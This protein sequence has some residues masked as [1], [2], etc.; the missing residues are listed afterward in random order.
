MTYGKS[1]STD[2]LVILLENLSKIFSPEKLQEVSHFEINWSHDQVGDISAPGCTIRFRDYITK[3]PL[4]K[5]SAP[6]ISEDMYN[7]LR[8][9]AKKYNI[10]IIV[11]SSSPESETQL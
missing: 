7:T 11:P 5:E 6:D 10:K 1:K 9:M 8:E 3:L 4:S 2:K